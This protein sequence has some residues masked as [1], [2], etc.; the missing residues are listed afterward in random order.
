[1]KY[2]FT[3][4][5][6]LNGTKD[7]QVQE[8]QVI[9]VENERITEILPAEEAGKR[10][11]KAS[12]YEEI[13]LQGKYI[14]PGLINMHVHLAGNGKPQKKQRDNEA[15]VKK[16]MSNGLTKAIAYNMVCGFAK[17]ELYSG[18]TT[19]R[20]VGGL[21]DFD[22]R[23]RDD[24]AAGKKPGPRILAANEGI[25]VPGGHMAGSVAI[26]ADSVEE[27]LQHL[28]TSKAQKV[29]LVKLMITGG[30]LDA[31]EKGVPGELKMAP[32]MVKA[33]CDKAHTMG[34]MVA[35]HVESPEGVKV[36]LKNGVDSIEHGAKADEEMISLFKEH[37][38]FLCTTLSPAL[39]YALF[40]RSITNAS[41]VEQFN[42][43]VVFEG[44]IDCAKAAIA[45]DIPVVL[46]N[47]VGCPWI[48][49]YDFWRELYYFHKYVGVSNAFA[50][51]T[52][53]CR[54]AEMAGIGDITGTLEPGKCAD[55]IV[56]EKNPLEDL[57]VLRNV[58]MVIAQGKVIR[59][60]KVKKK[61]IVE[62]ELDKFLN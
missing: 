31:K 42:G 40:D 51:Y 23:L 8:G 49:Q 53:T 1:M 54:G 29:D 28:E 10:N 6:I 20:T 59:A 58:D 13:D 7:M 25:S 44:I 27:A 5:K 12:G 32:E 34:Y 47:D 37:N 3:N 19:I 16:I 41:E 4:G 17:D 55:M 26:A 22:T 11:L 57:R 61:Q 35:A 45:N 14:L 9:L 50:L 21:G 43:N 2:V 39:P 62:T 56:V 30:V 46:G 33:V 18:V 15:L 52:A 24:I 60:P 38:A 36:A 48:T